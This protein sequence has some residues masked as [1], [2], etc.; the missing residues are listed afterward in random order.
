MISVRNF[1]MWS[2]EIDCL[3][4]TLRD[5]AQKQLEKTI[6]LVDLVTPRLFESTISQARS[7][8]D[9]NLT[10]SGRFVGGVLYGITLVVVI[11]TVA[12]DFI[13]DFDL[14]ALTIK[15]L[16]NAGLGVAIF[17]A[18]AWLGGWDRHRTACKKLKWL[19]RNRK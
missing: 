15:T 6:S 14:T 17:S 5:D 1:I 2:T 11:L 13:A 9:T 19:A 16:I 10:S 7:R 8:L 12:F 4:A 18:L 3:R